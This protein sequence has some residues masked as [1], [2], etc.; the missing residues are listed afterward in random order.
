MEFDGNG[1]PLC[2]E[3]YKQSKP[4]IFSQTPTQNSFYMIW[5]DLRSTGKEDLK[6]IYIQSITVGEESISSISQLPLEF[7]INGV[8]PNPFNPVTT[9]SYSI[10]QLANVKIEIINLLGQTV[11]VLQNE[12]V[13]AGKHQ[14]KWHPAEL[15]SGSYLVRV[16]Y[17]DEFSQ[18][19][20]VMLI[21]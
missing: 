21:K 8:F 10:P 13:H 18:T 1:Y 3:L 16:N 15:V 7:K 14:L 9:I 2:N 17:N 4:I 19:Q 20:Q 12:M 6:N 5:M 11:E